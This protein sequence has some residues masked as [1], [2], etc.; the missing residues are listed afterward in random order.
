MSHRAHI[1]VPAPVLRAVSGWLAR[2]RRAP[3]ARPWQRAATVN[4]HVLLVLGWLRHALDVPFLATRAGVSLS[5]GYRYLHEGLDVIAAHAPDLGEVCQA[6]HAAARRGDLAFVGLD[7]TLVPTDRVA[8]R[9]PAGNDEWYSGKHRRHGGNVQVLTDD[10]GF[11]LWVSEVRPG[12]WHDLACARQLVLPALYPHSALREGRLPVL[13]DKG[14]TGA[15]I[16]M[17]VPLRRPKGGQQ[18]AVDNR[19]YNALVTAT[20][21][22]TERANALLG[23]ARALRRVTLDPTR[24]TAIARAALVIITLLRGR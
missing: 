10:T 21:A 6:A 5:T 14:Y 17:L 12:S 24:I 23:W 2:A 22:P 20:R 15:G 11:P 18:L 16:G 4:A 8:A 9:T 1:D 19:T 7:G 13:A 3:G